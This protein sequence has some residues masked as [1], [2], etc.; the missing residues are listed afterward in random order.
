MTQRQTT[1]REPGGG[2]DRDYVADSGDP[3]ICDPHAATQGLD[4]DSL[5]L[6]VNWKYAV[7]ARISETQDR[8]ETVGLHPM[9]EANLIAEVAAFKEACRRA[10]Q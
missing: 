8:F 9:E 1:R 5:A 3:L 2:V 10:R 6:L 7:L 4:L